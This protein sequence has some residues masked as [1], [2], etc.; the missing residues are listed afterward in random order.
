MV[1]GI[2]KA[3]YLKGICLFS[4]CVCLHHFLFFPLSPSL[5]YITVREAE[6][7]SCDD[8]SCG[9]YATQGQR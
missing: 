3:M 4:V 7:E 5:L 1:F 2:F 9:S 6:E 8:A